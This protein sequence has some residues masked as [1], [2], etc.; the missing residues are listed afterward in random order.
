MVE[1]VRYSNKTNHDGDARERE[2][3]MAEN[4]LESSEGGEGQRVNLD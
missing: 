4:F 1:V 2:R 3:E